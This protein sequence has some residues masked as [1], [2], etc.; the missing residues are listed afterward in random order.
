MN[1]NT[2]LLFAVLSGIAFGAVGVFVRIFSAAGINNISILALRVVPAVMIM[3]ICFYIYDKNILKIK[4]KD[5]W[6]FAC[7]GILGTT[8]MNIF[9]NEAVMRISLS[10]TAVLLCLTPAIVMLFSSAIFD[11]KITIKKIACMLFILIG[12]LLVSGIME[13]NTTMRWSS[14]GIAFGFLSAVF[15]AFYSVFSKLAVKRNYNGLTIAFYSILFV[16]AVTSLFA[17]WGSAVEYIKSDPFK[18]FIIILCHSVCTS[19][20]P[21]GLYTVSLKYAEA[22]K[23]SMLSTGGEPIA[24]MIFGFVFFTEIPTILCMIGMIVTVVAMSILCRSGKE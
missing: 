22:G 18:N 23:A 8:G 4:I 21:Y 3:L 6:I 1:K 16:A 5:I 17:D 24:A 11:E 7:A 10:L 19:V 14:A 15:Y 12:C 2:A 9:Y 20:L 13:N